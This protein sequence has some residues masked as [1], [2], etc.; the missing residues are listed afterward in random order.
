MNTRPLAAP[1]TR[2]L[3]RI[4]LGGT[5]TVLVAWANPTPRLSHGFRSAVVEQPDGSSWWCDTPYTS[6]PNPNARIWGVDPIPAEWDL[7]PD[8]LRQRLKSGDEGSRSLHLPDWAAFPEE[9]GES[10]P[11]WTVASGWPM[12]CLV[13]HPT[14]NAVSPSTTYFGPWDTRL[15]GAGPWAMP[16]AGLILP[17]RPLWPGFL[18]NTLFFTPLAWV[19]LTAPRLLRHAVR[20]RRGLCPHCAYDLGDSPTCPECGPQSV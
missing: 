5:I 19:A 13:G 15:G 17:L 10:D 9:I 1:L 20:Q 2:L 8:E 12:R 18:V 4:I 16:F 7:T 14:D 6:D 3:Q 11:V